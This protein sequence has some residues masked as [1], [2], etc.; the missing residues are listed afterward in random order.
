M[1]INIDNKDFEIIEKEGHLYI[2]EK[3]ISADIIEKGEGFCVRLNGKNFQIRLEEKDGQFKVR[4]NGK[5]TMAKVT[6]KADEILSKIG[7]SDWSK[8]EE[9]DLKAPMPGKILD[10]I[11]SKGDKVEK[12]DNLVILEA[13]KMENMLKSPK[14]GVVDEIKI[15][16]GDTVEKNQI[17]V[18]FED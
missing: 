7:I 18:T 4:S 17:L 3:K 10:V 1:K 8:T 14:D 6:S 11:V 15:I 13:M 12:G 2:N 5:S 16:K 9:A